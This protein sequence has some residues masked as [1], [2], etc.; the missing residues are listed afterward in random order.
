MSGKAQM[1]DPAVFLLLHQVIIDPVPNK[2]LAPGTDDTQRPWI[3]AL[4]IGYSELLPSV[5]TP[6]KHDGFHH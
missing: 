5:N 4:M 6:T 3:D 1:T 2:H